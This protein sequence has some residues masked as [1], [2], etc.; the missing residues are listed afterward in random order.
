MVF[1][2]QSRNYGAEAWQKRS[3]DHD[4]G[5]YHALIEDRMPFEMVNDRLLD[6]EHLKG[7]KL[8]VLPNI[9]CLSD[10]QCNELKKFAERGGSIVATFET[11]LYNEKGEK[12]S[13]F[14][15]K[16]L[17]GISFDGVEGPMQNSYLRL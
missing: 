1:S 17:F 7:F 8:L 2:E 4:L 13:D 9:A 6:A 14:G 11:S 10:E 16:E 12:R 5:M 15:L 3:G